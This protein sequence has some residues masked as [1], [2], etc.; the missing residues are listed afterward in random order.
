MPSTVQ[1]TA[2]PPARPPR[3][4]VE[5]HTH[6]PTGRVTLRFARGV[7]GIDTASAPVRRASAVDETRPSGPPLTGAWTCRTHAGVVT[8]CASGAVR[9]A[10]FR[11]SDPFTAH[12]AY[13]LELNPEHT[14]QI[15]DARGNPYDRDTQYFRVT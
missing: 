3:V 7:S 6:V 14:L 5:R 2:L 1:V 9:S 11:P 12:R 4:T 13:L 8:S 10:V 15:T